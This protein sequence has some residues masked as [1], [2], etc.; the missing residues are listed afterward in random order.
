MRQTYMV[1]NKKTSVD[2][3][4]PHRYALYICIY[5]Y[6][7]IYIYIYIYQI[8]AKEVIYFLPKYDLFQ[9]S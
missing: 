1:C 8:V 4:M 3:K 7:Y 9:E 2:N 6:K 5:V